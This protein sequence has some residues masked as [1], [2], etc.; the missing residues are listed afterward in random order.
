[1]AR[2]S[3]PQQGPIQP[4][5]AEPHAPAL[6]FPVEVFL[7][8][9]RRFIWEVAASL[10]CPPDFVAVPMLALLGCAI[11]TSRVL[12]VKPGWLEGPRIYAAVVAETGTKKSPALKLAAAPFFERQR[13]ILRSYLD[14]SGVDGEGCTEPCDAL[15]GQPT[16]PTARQTPSTSTPSTG[17]LTAPPQV[18]T[19]DT[20]FEALIVLVAQNPRGVALIQDELSA[21]LRSLD[22][23]RPSGRGADRQRWLSLWNGAQIIVNR[24]SRMQQPIVLENPFVCIAGCLP[25]DVLNELS[26]Q[27]GREDGFIHRLLFGFPDHM[28]VRWTNAVVSDQALHG[29]Q[30][31]CDRLWDLQADLGQAGAGPS[32]PIELLFTAQGRGAFIQF[33]QTLYDELADPDLPED[34]RGPFAKLDGYGA[35]L[36]LILHVCRTV[37]GEADT[38]DVDE[39][40]V[41]A[42]VRLTDYFKA[43]AQRVYARL[44]STRADQRAAQACRWIRSAG[45]SCTIRDLQRYRVAGVRR[46]SEAEKLVRD[47]L[48]LGHGQ[49]EERQLSSGRVQRIFVLH[50]HEV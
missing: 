30:Q 33:A 2:R 16:E 42:M 34:W 9:L 7:S 41:R 37:C 13:T 44:R 20:T 39:P 18:F 23:Y 49:V 8:P 6:P 50:N 10:P 5:T 12:R 29:Y 22:M 45:G 11:G 1:M 17:D 32:S 48:D 14:A 21:W 35:R 15:P 3:R 40:S 38:E 4:A 27:R 31:V 19:T 24:K 46:A 36:A 47:L 26:D 43:H 25:P 28:P